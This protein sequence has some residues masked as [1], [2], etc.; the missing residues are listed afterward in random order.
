M[1]LP[2][3]AFIALAAVGWADGKLD[4]DEGAALLRAA[5]ASGLGGKDLAAVEAAIRAPVQIAD[6]ETARLSRGQRVLTYALAT[7]LTRLDGVVT[8]EEDESLQLLG[9]RLGLPTGV[10]AKA[11]AAATEVAALPAGDRPDRY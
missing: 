5:S 9:S 4:A 11:G 1:Q 7:W 3:D 6:A 2:R 8:A 10:R